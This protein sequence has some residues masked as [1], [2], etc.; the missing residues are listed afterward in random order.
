MTPELGRTDVSVA[1]VSFAQERLWLI[2]QSAPGS[3][4]YSVPMLLHWAGRVDL[5]ALRTALD[6]LV[7]RHDALRTSYQLR[8]DRVVQVVAERH[9]VPLA[10][11]DGVTDVRA[12]ALRCAREGFDLA[13]APPVRCVLWRG[14]PDGDT[15]LLLI[16]HIAVDG[17]S[18]VP[19]FEDL[20]ELYRAALAGELPTP[21]PDGHRYLDYA[22]W[23]RQ[24][25]ED[26]ALREQLRRR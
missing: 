8:G 9:V 20:T 21:S 24:L 5:A 3:P 19:L 10:V 13:A 16:H 14:G 17:W 2:D 23:D 15:V 4:T 18:L 7:A 12:D 26:P 22:E 11:L 1:P 25:F 6:G